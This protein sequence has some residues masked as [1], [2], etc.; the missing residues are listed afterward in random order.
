ME[1]EKK[2]GFNSSRNNY[3]STGWNIKINIY[4]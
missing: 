2:F 1:F 3:N 4:L